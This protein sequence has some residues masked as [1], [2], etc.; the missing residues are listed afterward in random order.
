MK[1][2]TLTLAAVAIAG[3]VVAGVALGRADGSVK[4]TAK[5]SPKQVVAQRSVQLASGTGLF[6]AT[7][8]TGSRRNHLY[9]RLTTHGLSS[10]ATNAFI[11]L[12]KAGKTGP[13]VL[14]VCGPC[15][16]L[17]HGAVYVRGKL[18]MRALETGGTY[19][20]VQTKRHPKGEIRG[21]ITALH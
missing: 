16:P 11:H 12:G 15:H 5:L 9:W 14:I 17:A 20:E 19:I 10:R 3:L 4:L 7:L 21:Q 6:T 8:Q 2:V 1:N 18:L 13:V